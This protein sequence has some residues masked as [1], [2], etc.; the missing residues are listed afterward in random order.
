MT[1]PT[2]M[3]LDWPAAADGGQRLAVAGDL[4][5][6]AVE[7]TVAAGTATRGRGPASAGV[8]EDRRRRRLRA[9]SGRATRCPVGGTRSMPAFGVMVSAEFPSDAWMQ[10][11]VSL[12]NRDPE[13]RAS[14]QGWRGSVG[15]IILATPLR[16]GP[17]DLYASLTGRQGTW[18]GWT[19]TDDPAAIDG[20][21]FAI[22]APYA[23]WKK[24]IRGELN[25]YKGIV[26]G[27]LRLRGSTQEAL[28]WARSI[29]ILWR[30]AQDVDSCFVDEHPGDS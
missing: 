25:P 30:L 13:F 16:D 2:A 26:L 15:M 8:S 27:R 7:R 20:T 18:T 10:R 4:I 24:V 17:R 5:E 14:G 12:A 23:Q 21:E 28:R 22:E 19:L 1:L 9:R 29:L 11:W 6:Q 3:L